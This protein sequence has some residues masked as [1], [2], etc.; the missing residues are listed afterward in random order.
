MDIIISYLKIHDSES[1]KSQ[2]V[3]LCPFNFKG[4]YSKQDLTK[5][6]YNNLNLLTLVKSQ[7]KS[8]RTKISLMIKIRNNI[9]PRWDFWGTLADTKVSI[10]RAV[11]SRDT[12]SLDCRRLCNMLRHRQ[13]I[14]CWV[15][16]HQ[17]LSS[18]EFYFPSCGAF[19]CKG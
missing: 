6:V 9:G 11:E 16:S 10:K 15:E 14:I 3:F 13:R 5:E 7:E 18:G 17:K 1:T 8:Q 12:R 4:Q 19:W 2:K